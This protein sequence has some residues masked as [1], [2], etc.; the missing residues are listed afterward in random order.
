MSTKEIILQTAMKLFL[1]HGY[2]GVSISDIVKTAK[3]SKGGLY[4]YFSSKEEL[5]FQA[6][7]QTS[8][9]FYIVITRDFFQWDFSSF[10][11]F[12]ISFAGL[13]DEILSNRRYRLSDM[14][15]L[16]INAAKIFPQLN[17][18][19]KDYTNVFRKI[20]C[21]N[22]EKAIRSGELKEDLSIENTTEIYLNLI[23]GFSVNFVFEEAFQ[24]ET[25]TSLKRE[26]DI[27]YSL[28]KTKER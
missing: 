24:S 28:I 27:M 15:V 13:Y 4:N 14:L 26:F 16:M 1:A 2:E 5:F 11:E 18:E 19:I 6:L 3:I 25:K 10:H 20:W 17:Q 7:S 23:N 22:I 9:E 12:Y 21:K 8:D